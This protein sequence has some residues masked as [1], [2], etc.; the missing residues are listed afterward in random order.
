MIIYNTWYYK[1]LAKMSAWDVSLIL[2][3][4]CY[5]LY[6][7][8]TSSF[9]IGKGLSIDKTFSKRLLYTWIFLLGCEDE[10]ES[11]S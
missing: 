9:H 10:Q 6:I 11:H 8:T 2:L 1:F 3:E 4:K 7:I 5:F